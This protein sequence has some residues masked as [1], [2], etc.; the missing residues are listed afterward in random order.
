MSTI[1][2]DSYLLTLIEQA[3][4]EFST[5]VP[6]LWYEKTLAITAGTAAYAVP[7]FIKVL[8]V[9]YQGYS[10]DPLIARD[11]Q[12]SPQTFKP[13]SGGSR[14]R[15]SAYIFDQQGQST[16]RFYPCPNETIAADDT[17]IYDTSLVTGVVVISGYVHHQ[18][19]YEVPAYLFR[20]MMKYRAMERAYAREGDGQNLKASKHFASVYQM[21]FDIYRLILETIPKK[22]PSELAGRVRDP[23][24]KPPRP[25][26][27]TTGAWSV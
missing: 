24:V 4:I 6:G 5:K 18:T 22:I 25:V 26:F 23:G 9:S 11:L 3:A 14:G 7:D 2:S 16:L 12:V 10:L 15:P 17:A 1:F 19:D 8:D 21:M 20:N 27:P 13:N